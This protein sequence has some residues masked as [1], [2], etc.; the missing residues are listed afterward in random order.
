MIDG[1]TFI[2]DEKIQEVESVS[3]FIS[4]HENFIDAV[5]KNSLNTPETSTFNAIIIETLNLAKAVKE[6]WRCVEIFAALDEA[7][8][9]DEVDSSSLYDL[10]K[11]AIQIEKN[12]GVCEYQ[13]KIMFDNFD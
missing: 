5:H 2:L 7:G 4:L 3:E 1:L 9:L 10:D 13:L 12:F 11:Q 6:T 8:N